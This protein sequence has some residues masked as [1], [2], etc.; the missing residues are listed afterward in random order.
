MGQFD[1]IVVNK[2]NA[3]LAPIRSA[4]LGFMLCRKRDQEVSYDRESNL[5]KSEDDK[6]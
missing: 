3:K 1:K 6:Y 2:S 4:K 5:S